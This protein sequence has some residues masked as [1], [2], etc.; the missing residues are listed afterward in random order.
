MFPGKTC[1][2]R[3]A[4]VVTLILLT[5]VT[6]CS[7]KSEVVVFHAAS[8]AKTFTEL[9]RGFGKLHPQKR[10][11]VEVSGSQVAA[12]KVAE[13]GMRAD[14]VAVA[15]S[16]VIDRILLPDHASWNLIF[17]ANELVLAHKDHS[18][19]T[20]TVNTENWHTIVSKPNV[21][22]GRANADTA[23]IGYRTLLLWQLAG[24]EHGQ[25]TLEQTLRERC[26]KEHVVPDES[27]L[28]ALLESR[29]VDYVFM[30]RSTAEE[31]H[32]KITELSP[33]YNFSRPSLAQSY[34][35]A[36]TPVRMG[37]NSMTMV[38][39]APILYGLTIPKTAS[40][41]KDAELFIQFMLSDK[42]QTVLKRS[43]YRPLNPPR[44]EH[45]D[46]AP[47]ALKAMVTRQ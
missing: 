22:L 39:G 45:A 33:S 41:P 38:V 11:R 1:P 37:N 9:A 4:W 18:A 2:R 13:L 43:G 28:L 34:G 7:S 46:K 47:A 20:E 36:S 5:A 26:A 15:D 21:R 25:P 6:G 23:P 12:R 16:A 44:L 17:A 3:N 8:L 31:H 27:Y 35:R 40:K 32:L 24:L 29:S 30:Y 19:H 10:V 42:G 14:I